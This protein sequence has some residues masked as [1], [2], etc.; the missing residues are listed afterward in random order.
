MKRVL[1]FLILLFGFMPAMADII[2][3]GVRA[4]KGSESAAQ[5]WQST[6]DYLSETIS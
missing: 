4:H 5:R 1:F 6:A 3:I 2:K